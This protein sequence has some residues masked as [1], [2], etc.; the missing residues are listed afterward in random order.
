MRYE[1]M[2]NVKHHE[3]NACSRCCGPRD[4]EGQRYCRSCHSAY[5][6][7]K[8]PKYKDLPEK[9]KKKNI[10]RS[11]ARMYQRRGKLIQKPCGR[12]GSENSEKH[13]PDYDKPLTVEWLCRPCH[14]EHHNGTGGN[15]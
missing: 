15:Q 11:Y 10:A 1:P 9:E 13:H 5:M 6:K 14:A 3:K 8:R 7:E 4:R 2:T 12:C